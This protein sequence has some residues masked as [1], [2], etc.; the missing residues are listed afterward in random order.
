MTAAAAPP[1]LPPS[2]P[3]AHPPARSNAE[4][5]RFDAALKDLFEQRIS[6]NQTLGLHVLAMRAGDVRIGFEMRPALVGHHS[7][8]RLHGGVTSAVLDNVGALALM[9]AIADHHPGDTAMQV[10]QRFARMGTI[11]LRV[12]YLRPGHSERFVASAEVL[13]L[14]GRVATTQMRLSADD[15]TL[16]ATGAAAYIVS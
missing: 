15:G 16:V 7:T 9:V 5:A 8:G 10:M 6:F 3:P 14:G 13:R 2:L 4:Q 12:D 1:G 11:D